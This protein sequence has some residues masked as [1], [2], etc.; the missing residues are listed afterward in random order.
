[1]NN[2]NRI[3][4]DNINYI[5]NNEN[6]VGGNNIDGYGNNIDGY[7]NNIDEDEI[8][9]KCVICFENILNLEE[10]VLNKICVCTDSLVCNKCLIYMENNNIKKCPVC[11]KNLNFNKIKK[12][13]FN[14]KNV[15]L[16]YIHFIVFI[17]CNVI[18]YNVALNYKYYNNGT[19]YPIISNYNNN[20]NNNKLL[21][22]Y[23]ILNDDTDDIF[24][25]DKSHE[26]DIRLSNTNY[27]VCKNSIIYKK[28]IYFFLTNLLINIL[29]PLVLGINNS[30]SLYKYHNDGESS[31]INLVI[32]YILT[33]INM[34]TIGVLCFV[35]NKINHL[36]LLLMLNTILYGILFFG[37]IIA[38]FFTYFDLFYKHMRNQNII[39]YIKYNIINRII[40]NT[41]QSTDV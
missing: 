3:Y 29:F 1:M 33:S 20:N 22:Y 19:D 35:E 16:Y 12:Y 23:N 37:A 9:Y 14:F 15:I 17:L 4:Y 24:T 31:K 11:R 27:E 13:I 6:N 18:I 30:I 7:G 36:R 39:E 41:I 34:L 5:I 10:T 40:L 8:D 26:L 32:I 25:I 28:K 38:Y 2:Y 21:N